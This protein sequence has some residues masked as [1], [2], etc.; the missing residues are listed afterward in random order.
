MERNSIHPTKD[1][2]ESKSNKLK[3]KT[4]CLCLTGSVGIINSPNIARELMRHGAEVITVMSEEAIALMLKSF[5]VSEEKLPK[6]KDPEPEKFSPP[7][8]S[9]SERELATFENIRIIDLD[10]ARSENPNG[11]KSLY[12]MYLKLSSSPPLEW[13]QIFEAERRFPRHTMWRRAW[14][15]GKY[16]VIHCVPEELEQYHFHDL[17]EDTDS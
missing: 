1:I 5:G 3:G 11:A 9:T 15:E 14:I 16:I 8:L 10:L 17:S 6:V 4:I 13:V 12:N 7:T 2:I